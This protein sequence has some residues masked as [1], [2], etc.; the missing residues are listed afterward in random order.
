M[1]APDGLY[2]RAA[3][4]GMLRP[5]WHVDEVHT[6]FVGPLEYNRLHQH[7]APVFLAGIYSEFRLRIHGGNW[8]SCRTAVIP[9]GV[10]HELDLCGYPLA[11]FY[12]EPKHGGIEVLLSLS[13]NIWEVD[14]VVMGRS[15]EVSVMRELWEDRAAAR[16]AGLALEDLLRFS[17]RRAAK[18]RDTR[19]AAAIDYL[20]THPGELTS[21][22]PLAKSLGLSSSQFQR[23][24]TRE[25]GVPFRRY[26]AWNRMRVAIS[27]IVNGSNF[28]TAAHTAGFSDQA[29]FTNDFRRTFGA[30]PSVSLLA[31]RKPPSQ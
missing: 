21:V 31:L 17:A 26:R 15:G 19:I 16:W 25:V 13:G 5:F 14:G 11:V 30:P 4:D 29:H 2:E 24:F 10:F 6:F 28:T 1:S 27:E 18:N 22:S 8:H 3:P 9:A 7:G 20:R 23:I 12:V